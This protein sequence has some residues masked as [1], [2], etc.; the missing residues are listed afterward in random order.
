M[1]EKE[2]EAALARI[3]FLMDADLTPAESEELDRLVDEVVVY[4]SGP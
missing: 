1:N 4:E 2:H 3:L